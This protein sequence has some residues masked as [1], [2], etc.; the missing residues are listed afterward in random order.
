MCVCVCV[1]EGGGG[2]FSWGEEIE[3]GGLPKCPEMTVG[4]VMMQLRAF[5]VV[6]MVMNTCHLWHWPRDCHN[7]VQSGVWLLLGILYIPSVE[8][9]AGN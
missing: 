8:E 7:C 6:I 1:E 2:I 4:F 9:R 5:K 3:R